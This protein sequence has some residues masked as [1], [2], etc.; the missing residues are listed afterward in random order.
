MQEATTA[1]GGK[2]SV[3]ATST[4]KQS[5]QAGQRTD[6]KDTA[7]RPEATSPDT[8]NKGGNSTPPASSPASPANGVLVYSYAPT[9]T[10]SNTTD[11]IH[12]PK[13]GTIPASA[14]TLGLPIVISKETAKAIEAKK[15][16]D[17]VY[18]AISDHYTLLYGADRA[19]HFTDKIL[20]VF[21]PFWDRVD[22]IIRDSI[23]V[24]YGNI[25]KGYILI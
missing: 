11:R 20:D 8:C 7:N 1:Q 19:D 14:T 6:T 18:N 12:P 24:T 10:N 4:A 22:D 16:L 3:N 23:S 17:E 5:N 15:L 13:D 21:H 25:T 9:A 2:A